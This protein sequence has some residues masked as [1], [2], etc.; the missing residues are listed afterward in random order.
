MSE[1]T[2][3]LHYTQAELDRNYDQRT[4]AP[5]A[6]ELIGRYP[7]LSAA[8][9]R[10][11]PHEANVAYGPSADEVLDIFGCGQ[12]GAPTQVFIHGGA[13]RNFTKDD[14]SFAA[15]AFVGNGI[16]AVLVNFAKILQ[17]PLP[18]MVNQTRRAIA[19]AVKNVARWGGDPRR[20]YVSGHSSGAHQAAMSL[21]LGWS[22]QDVADD[23]I[24]GAHLVSGPYDLEPVLLSARSAYVKLSKQEEHDLSPQRHAARMRC[25]IFIAYGEHDTDE[26]QRHSRDFAA[27]LDRVGKLNAVQRFPGLNHFETMQAFNDPHS[28]LVQAIVSRMT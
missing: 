19:W 8:T 25:P 22:D 17:L 14:Y 5:N 9:R 1:A 7:M 21:A 15:E 16:N 6:L 28:A 27:A 26:F 24:R 23:A 3:F 10:R 12:A 2:V 18:L 11:L 13:W 4:W 20:I